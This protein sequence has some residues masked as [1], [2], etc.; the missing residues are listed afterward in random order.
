M[1]TDSTSLYPNDPSYLMISLEQ[2][3]DPIVLHK[4]STR[5]GNSGCAIYERLS[6][7]ECHLFGIHTT[8]IGGDDGLY[9]YGTYLHSTNIRN[10][11]KS[12]EGLQVKE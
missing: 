7:Q 10:W 3:G 9:N 2:N 4:L 8:G 1:Y 6:P 11:L 12:I 5:P